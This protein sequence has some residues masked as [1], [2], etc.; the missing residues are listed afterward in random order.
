MIYYCEDR[1]SRQ[2][3]AF[4]KEFGCNAAQPGADAGP[5]EFGA[6]SGIRKIRSD[7]EMKKLCRANPGSGRKLLPD[8]IKK[9]R[10]RTM[11]KRGQRG[12]GRGRQGRSGQGQG[13]GQFRNSPG[14][15]CLCPKCKYTE[16]H[17][18]GVPCRDKQCPQCGTPMIRE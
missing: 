2:L 7:R 14:G 6:C 5:A 11:Q 8:P 9:E 17:A 10:G 13:G 18:P 3:P 16:A 4:S 15:N 1:I 12:T